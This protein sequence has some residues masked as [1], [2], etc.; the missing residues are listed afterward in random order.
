MENKIGQSF[1]RFTDILEDKSHYVRRE[2]AKAIGTACSDKA[3]EHLISALSD[4][5]EFVRK[6]AAEALGE[7]VPEIADSGTAADALVRMLNDKSHFVRLKLQST[8]NDKIQRSTHP[9]LCAGG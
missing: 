6:A 4:E 2:A 3:L 9:L 1:E 7:I 8:G 5:D